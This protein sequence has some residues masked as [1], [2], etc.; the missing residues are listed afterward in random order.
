MN[1]KSMQAIKHLHKAR[2]LAK[3][4]DNPFKGL[5]KEEIINKLRASREKLWREKYAAGSRY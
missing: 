5:T 4:F 3:D 1:S 2:E